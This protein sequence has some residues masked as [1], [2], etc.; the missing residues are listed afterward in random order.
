MVL[1]LNVGKSEGMLQAGI[2]CSVVWVFCFFVVF[3]NQAD[4][5]GAK[6]HNQPAFKK[7]LGFQSIVALV[8]TERIQGLKQ[9]KIS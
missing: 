7:S 2:T 5:Y 8:S 3:L 4:G 6:H 1:T 9:L